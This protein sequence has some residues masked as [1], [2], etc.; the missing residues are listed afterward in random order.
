MRKKSNSP[1]R[2]SGTSPMKVVKSSNSGIGGVEMDQTR[3][4][5]WL[6]MML[7]TA[8]VLIAIS[9]IYSWSAIKMDLK[10]Q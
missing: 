7:H 3:N 1:K 10:D 4:N 5:Y 2:E 9:F 6:A 8:V